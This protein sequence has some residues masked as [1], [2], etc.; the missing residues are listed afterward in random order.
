[1]KDTILIADDEARFRKSLQEVF[2]SEGY[3]VIAARNG[4]EAVAKFEESN[5]D[6]VLLDVI[7]PVMNGFKACEEIRLRSK[8][9]PVIFLTG[10]DSET[11]EV[12]ALG[13]GA[14]D[15]IRKGTDRG[16][17]FARVRRALERAEGEIGGEEEREI[18]RLGRIRIDLARLTVMENGKIIANLTDTEKRLLQILL[19]RRDEVVSRDEILTI[20]RGEDFSISENMV[21]VHISHLRGKLG[22][23]ADMLMNIKSAGYRLIK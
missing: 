3:D 22:A 11:D 20:L 14:D 23:A 6:V 12:R 15:F 7:M 18:V 17:I 13:L 5:P 10:T 21:Y 4:E 9:V 2:E 1:M 19:A 8:L 16:V